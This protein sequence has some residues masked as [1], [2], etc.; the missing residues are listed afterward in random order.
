MTLDEFWTELG[1]LKGQF[2]I[3][4]GAIRD[5]DNLCPICAVAQMRGF[6]IHLD[7]NPNGNWFQYSELEKDAIFVVRAADYRDGSLRS[8]ML[9]VLGLT[10]PS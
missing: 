6:Q 5:I 7:H 8:K 9:E 10:E 1:K 2:R 4:E 3:K